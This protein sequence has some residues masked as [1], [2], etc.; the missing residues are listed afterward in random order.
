MLQKNHDIG[1]ERGVQTGPGFCRDRQA[2]QYV[3]AGHY[4]MDGHRDAACICG[5]EWRTMPAK[6]TAQGNRVGGH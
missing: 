3:A 1:A 6:S 2:T 5:H 4:L